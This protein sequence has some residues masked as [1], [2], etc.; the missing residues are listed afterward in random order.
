MGA[1][2]S[3]DIVATDPVPVPGH[4]PRCNT[5]RLYK[6]EMF[7]LSRDG[8]NRMGHKVFCLPCDTRPVEE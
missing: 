8:L 7:R 4:C 1:I 2:P 5:R 6:I 3:T